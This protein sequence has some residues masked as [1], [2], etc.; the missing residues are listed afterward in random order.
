MLKGHWTFQFHNNSLFI[1]HLEPPTEGPTPNFFKSHHVYVF[2]HVSGTAG[3]CPAQYLKKNKC[4]KFPLRWFRFS[5]FQN[6]RHPMQEALGLQS[7]E[8]SVFSKSESSIVGVCS[9]YYVCQDVS[10]II[11]IITA[12]TIPQAKR[13]EDKETQQKRKQC[14]NCSN[15]LDSD[16]S[17][18]GV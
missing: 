18:S 14:A 4:E 15:C 9:S 6:F 13:L 10:H 5:V 1:P 17:R 7:R 2:H 11:Q 3:I 8:V 12:I 16:F